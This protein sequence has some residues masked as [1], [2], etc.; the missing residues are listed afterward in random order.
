[1]PVTRQGYPHHNKEFPLGKFLY[2]SPADTFELDDRTLAHVEIVVLAKLRRREAFALSIETPSGEHS[3]LWIGTNS[4]LQFRFG[5][6]DHEIN[7]SWLETMIDSANSPAGLK[8]VPEES[9]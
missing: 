7:R 2:G 6:H 3:T 9:V 4:T 1:M 8:I 5:S